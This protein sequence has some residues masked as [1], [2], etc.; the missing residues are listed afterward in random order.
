MKS[1]IAILSIL[2]L[3]FYIQQGQTQDKFQEWKNTHNK[4]YSQ[5]EEVFRKNIFHENLKIINS[6]NEDYTQTYK[7]GENSFMDLTQEEFINIYLQPFKF[8]NTITNQTLEGPVPNGVDWRGITKVKEQGQCASGWAF[9]VTGTLE[10]FYYLRGGKQVI[11]ASE[12]QLVDCEIYYSKGCQ[13]GLPYYAFQ[14]LLTYGLYTGAGYP[15]VAFQ[16]TCRYTG[17]SYRIN[18]YQSVAG[19]ANLKYALQTTPVSVGVDA[20]NWQFYKSGYFNNC[21]KSINHFVLAV[22]FED[23]GAWIVK[24]SFGTTWGEQGHIRLVSGDTCA[25]TQYAYQ[26]I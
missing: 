25:I 20:S 3:T 16:S 5:A 4:R 24:N 9:S 6:H 7:M 15:Y 12:Q 17:G 22:G 10:G 18:N 23:S 1:I 11:L 8:E 2:A 21:Q 19:E 13:G 26:A 14:Y